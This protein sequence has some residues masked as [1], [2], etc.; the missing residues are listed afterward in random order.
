M[1]KSKDKKYFVNWLEKI[2]VKIHLI[3]SS[4][5]NYKRFFQKNIEEK[6]ELFK[7]NYNFWIRYNYECS[8]ILA[9]TSLI[10]YGSHDDDL[11]FQKFL[12]CF[13]EYYGSNKQSLIIEHV[14][15]KPKYIT[16]FNQPNITETLDDNDP[17]ELLRL[18]FIKNKFDNLNIKNDIEVLNKC[19]KKLKTVR[20]KLY[21][22]YTNYEEDINITHS[23]I[24]KIIDTIISVFDN[25]SFILKNTTYYFG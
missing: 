21:A 19:F 12:R 15:D 4:Q 25:Y 8:L 5:S 20:D 18:D 23:E 22:H 1:N 14:N 11:S 10:E 3:K 17:I 6:I 16:D 9:I 24:E 2:S 13:S 7:S